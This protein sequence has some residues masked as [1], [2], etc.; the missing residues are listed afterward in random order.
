MIVIS[1]GTL[2]YK[3]NEEK[4]LTSWLAKV[5]FNKMRHNFVTGRETLESG[6]LI[7]SILEVKDSSVHS[8]QKI[9]ETSPP[10]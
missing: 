5:W 1:W 4:I 6:R 10:K 8:P 7:G 3:V 2:R 9:S